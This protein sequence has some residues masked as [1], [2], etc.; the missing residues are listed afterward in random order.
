MTMFD[1]RLKVH[2]QIEPKHM[3][4]LYLVT[5][6]HLQIEPKP[7]CLYLGKAVHLQIELKHM[8]VGKPMQKYHRSYTHLSLE[9]HQEFQVKTHC[10]S[11]LSC[12]HLSQLLTHL[13]LSLEVHQEFQVKTHCP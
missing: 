5:A 10:P 7:M 9:V 1:C 8:L 4:S 6:V 12:Y 13:H 3:C 2:L 11:Y